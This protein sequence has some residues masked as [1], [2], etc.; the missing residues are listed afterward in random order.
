MTQNM[1]MQLNANLYI[2]HGRSNSISL[3][4]IFLEL[5]KQILYILYCIIS[6]DNGTEEFCHSYNKIITSTVNIQNLL[7]KYVK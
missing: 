2:E 6:K 1:I 5:I 3:S 7:L 4:K